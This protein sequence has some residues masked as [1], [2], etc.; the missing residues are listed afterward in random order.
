VPH[1]SSLSSDSIAFL[2]NR[3]AKEPLLRCCTGQSGGT[4]DSPMNYSGACPE[5][6]ESGEFETVWSWCTG[7]CL[8]AHRRSGAPDQGT[9]GSFA[10]LY[11]NPNFDLLLVCLNLYAPVEYNLEQTS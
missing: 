7:H 4:P 8:V 6:P 11:L 2:V 5:N 3:C 9:L 1:C 10:P